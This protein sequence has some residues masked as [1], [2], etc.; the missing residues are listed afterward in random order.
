MA[1]FALRLDTGCRIFHCEDRMLAAKRTVQ[2]GAP[3]LPS[4]CVITWV[5]TFVSR[6][7]PLL[8][9]SVPGGNRTLAITAGWG[10]DGGCVLSSGSADFSIVVRRFISPDLGHTRCLHDFMVRSDAYV[11]PGGA[12]NAAGALFSYPGDSPP[13]QPSSPLGRSYL[14][15]RSDPDP[16]GS[17]GGLA[18][19]DASVGD[20]PGLG[21]RH[22][23]PGSVK[24]PH[25]E[26]L[27]PITVSVGVAFSIA[28]DTLSIA[29]RRPSGGGASGAVASQASLTI[30]GSRRSWARV[31]DFIYIIPQPLLGALCFGRCVV[32][33]ACCSFPGD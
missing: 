24:H 2:K 28:G 16:F 20:L 30:F 14:L 1:A 5:V 4:G 21:Q 15:G 26:L 9:C 13:A 10:I 3:M 17:S 6:G 31:D 22:N 11:C 23:L 25:P 29:R 27:W 8:A 7:L 12:V 18:G 33:G 32:G 19:V